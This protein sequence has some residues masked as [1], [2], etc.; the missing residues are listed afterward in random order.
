MKRNQGNM[1]KRRNVKKKKKSFNI[2][3]L[4]AIAFVL[5]FGFTF[6]DQQIKINKYNSQ[7][8]MYNKEIEAKQ[9]LVEYYNTQSENITSDEYIESVARERLGLVKP[10]ETIY[11]DANK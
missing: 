1:R 9:N 3:H 10:Y 8:E 7:I 4:A 2:V 11:V 6:C 5:Y